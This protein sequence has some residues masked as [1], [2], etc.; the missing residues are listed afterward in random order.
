MGDAG[1]T[2]HRFTSMG[3]A[4]FFLLVNGGE[5]TLIDT[6]NKDRIANIRSKF[7]RTGHSLDQLKRIIPTH[8]HPDHIGSM[9]ALKQVTGAQVLAHEAETPYIS[10]EAVLPRAR[11]PARLLHSLTEPIFRAEPCQVD[12]TLKHG[13]S[14]EGTGLTVIHMPGHSPGSVCL[15]H[16]ANRALFTGDALVNMFGKV[17]G[18]VAAFCWDIQLAHRSLARLMELDV[19][20]L[21]FAHGKTIRGD[22]NGE[23]RSLVELFNKSS[24]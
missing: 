24:V 10:H 12:R 15:Y 18:P 13:D 16:S 14:I 3:I 19:E 5:L 20:T 21:Y 8:C 1:Y 17:R 22:A 6:G 2:V 11:G 7:E 4:N 9:A 23:I